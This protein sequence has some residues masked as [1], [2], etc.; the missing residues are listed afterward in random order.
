M[1][2]IAS[3]MRRGPAGDNPR[4]RSWRAVASVAF[5]AG[6]V[7]G[8]PPAHA[9]TAEQGFVLTLPTDLYVAGGTLTVALSFVLVACIPV[10]GDWAG[11]TTRLGQPPRAI[12]IAASLAALA[13]FV[14][15][16]RAG[17]AGT[18]DP[19]ANPLPL[20]VWTLGWVGFTAL[21]MVVGGLWTLVNPWHGVAALL[22]RAPL[23]YPRWLGAWPAVAGLAGLAWFELIHTT[24]ANPTLLA[25]VVAGY[26]MATL[27]AVA[28]FGPAWLRH[29]ETFGAYFRMVSWLAPVG[30]AADDDG[31]FALRWPGAR[32]VGLEPQGPGV[33]AFVLLALAT[34]SFD[35]L[36]RTF[37]WLDLIGVN[38]LDFPGRSAVGGANTLGLFGLFALLAGAFAA[39]ARAG[40]ALGGAATV[41]A[42]APALV[43]IALGYHVAHYLPAFLVDAQ[44][45]AHALGAALGFGDGHGSVITSFLSD[46]A[47]VWLIWHVQ[48]AIVVAAHVVAVAVGH[49]RALHRAPSRRAAI[50]GQLPLTALMIG[51]TLFGLW[52]LA[53][54]AI[55]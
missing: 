13:C 11:R 31:P 50:L 47:G 52:L 15:L 7:P 33:A 8:A 4:A 41:G 45:A 25:W 10:F 19:L 49:A 37:A 53:A 51:Y 32:L 28:L 38:P 16:V 42:D 6:A 17:V 48:V 9:H 43:P 44:Y 39:C 30:R 3:V 36:A 54:P 18:Q 29:G 24:P 34:V 12:G 55:G 21:A 2:R 1:T 27:A 23:P 14:L 20:V 35:G 40:R 26:G 5:A 46:H 22:P